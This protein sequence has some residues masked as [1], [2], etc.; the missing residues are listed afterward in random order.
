[1]RDPVNEISDEDLVSHIQQIR[2][3]SPYSGVQMIC[4]NLRAK[5]I[6]VTR[7]RVCSTIKSIDPLGGLYNIVY[8]ILYNMYMYS[9]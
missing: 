1:M 3:D 6:K 9:T 4:G 2:Q 5:G 8:I 7:E